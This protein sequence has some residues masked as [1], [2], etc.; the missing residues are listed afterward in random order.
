MRKL[1][2][3]LSC[4]AIS[5]ILCAQKNIEGVI[6]DSKTNQPLAGVSI[7]VKSSKIGTT[8][9]AEGVFKIPVSERDVLEI[10]MVGY[11]P[12]T[13]PINSQSG[14]TINLEPTN[15]ELGEVVVVGNRGAPRTKIESPV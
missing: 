15:T 3:A 10:S 12:Q 14:I 8:S 5:G 1:F 11:K 2:L 9:N 7:K 13:L 6:K 4:I